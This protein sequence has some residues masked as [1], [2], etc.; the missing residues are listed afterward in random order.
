[1]NQRNE[2]LDSVKG[3]GM[4]SIIIGHSLTTLPIT[5]MKL[6]S[7]VY[8]YHIMLFFFVAGFLYDDNKYNQYGRIPAYIGKRFYGIFKLYVLYNTGFVLLHNLLVSFS[9]I[10]AESYSPNECLI[11]LLSGVTMQTNEAMLGAFWFLPV[12]FVSNVLFCLTFCIVIEISSHF[13]NHQIIAKTLMFISMLLFAIIGL[14][15][16]QC[17]MYLSYHIQTAFLAVP[18]MY[19]GY[20]VKTKYSIISPLFCWIGCFVSCVFLCLIV[21]FNVITVELS[22]NQIGNP[23]LFYPV[24]CLGLYFCMCLSHVLQRCTPAHKVL[25]FVG[26]Y[27]FHFMALHFITF[28]ILDRL[29]SLVR[30]DSETVAKLFPHSYDLGLTYTVV[31][32]I[33]ISILITLM[34]TAKKIGAGLISKKARDI[35]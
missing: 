12:F 4:L 24:T 18:V 23:V 1:M 33:V 17:G 15:T 22:V 3:I 7:F 19:I 28:K 21:Y 29:I 8:L 11:W 14:Y 26:R 27:S 10:T 2:M 20:I 34:N 9:L 35:P 25:S 5:H 32:V 13:C 30:C 31:S 16:N 6:G